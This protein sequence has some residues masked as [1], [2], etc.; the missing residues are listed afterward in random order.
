M[1]LVAD[2]TDSGGLVDAVVRQSK[3]LTRAL[4]TH[5]LATVTTVMLK[6][7]RERS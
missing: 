2:I 5:T 3:A 7:N 4:G 6:G 1:F